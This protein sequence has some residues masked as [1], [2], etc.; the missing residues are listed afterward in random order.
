MPALSF[1]FKLLLAMMI[2]VVGVTG[3]TLYVTQQRVQATYQRLSE[4]QFQREIQFHTA[5]QAARLYDVQRRSRNF[6]HSVRLRDLMR[7]LNSDVEGHDD[8]DVVLATEKLYQTAEDELQLRETLGTTPAGAPAQRAAFFRLLD[9]QGQV[10]APPSGVDAGLIHPADRKRFQQQLGSIGKALT[11]D[12]EEQVGYLAPRTIE[13]R[14]RLLEVIVTRIIDSR[15]GESVGTLALGFAVSNLMPD[16]R[17]DQSLN[18]ETSRIQ[19]GIWLDEQLYSS[20]IAEAVR[21]EVEQRVTVRA[22]TAQRVAGN[23]LAQI[24][25]GPYRVFYEALN[26]GANFPPA[27]QVC[28]YSLAE[29]LK[30]QKDLR[31]RILGFGGLALAG[32]LA[33]SLLL[34]HGLVGPIQQLVA[35]T[36]EIQ[37]GNFAVTVPVRSRDEIGHLTASFNEMAEGLALKEKYRS[38]LN[39]VTDKE[40]AQQLMNGSVALGGELREVSVLFCDIRGFTALTQNME[41][42]EVIH[43]LNEHMTALTRVVYEHDG[44]VDKFV[45]DLIMAVFGAP[46]NYRND[47]YNAARCAVRMIN[48]RQKLNEISRYKIRVGIGITSGPAVAGCMGSADR[49]NYTVLG[50]RVNLAARLC[51][52]AGP[53]EVVIDQTTHERL[54]AIIRAEPLP[55]MRLKGF[56]S[57]IQAFKLLEVRSLP[58]H[59]AK[60]A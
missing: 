54:A 4:E 25:G 5:L 27:Y 38:V 57:S 7:R 24:D 11:G 49:L 42:A 17:T 8:A 22:R 1:R 55:E 36:G 32:A 40:V 58:D 34:S 39:L 50:A 52:Q 31:T 18:V 3:T 47:A 19:S 51:S 33:V 53:M 12:T 28:L 56:S 43:L 44:V 45:G 30:E 6:A 16:S 23:Y 46:K 60:T 41:P 10:L 20:E 2:V 48:E 14:A 13:G 29:A 35:G 9:A 21:P 37:R 26:Q 15:T 59:H